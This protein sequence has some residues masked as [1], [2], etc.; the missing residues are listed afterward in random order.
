[1][2]LPSATWASTTTISG[3]PITFYLLSLCCVSNSVRRRCCSSSSRSPQRTRKNMVSVIQLW[4]SPC[5]TDSTKQRLLTMP[6]R[7]TR[8]KLSGRNKRLWRI[9]YANI[10]NFTCVAQIYLCPASRYAVCIPGTSIW[11]CWH[12]NLKL[13]SACLA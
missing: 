5:I 10:P 1:M 2:P 4:L 9:V 3:K 11:L 13:M 12:S 8:S 7:K 6:Q